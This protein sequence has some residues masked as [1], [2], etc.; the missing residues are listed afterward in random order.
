MFLGQF[1]V[2]FVFHKK[3]IY[4]VHCLNVNRMIKSPPSMLITQQVTL[5]LM[6]TFHLIE[7]LCGPVARGGGATSPKIFL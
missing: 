2:Y 6:I 4:N 3:K 5:I 7:N 1:W